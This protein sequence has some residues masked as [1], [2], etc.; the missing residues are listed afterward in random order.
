[1]TMNT[2]TILSTVLSADESIT[3]SQRARVLQI[4]KGEPEAVQAPIGKLLKRSEVAA[5]L[6]VSPAMID[7]YCR[8][9]GLKK[10]RLGGQSRATGIPEDSVRE[11]IKGEHNTAISQAS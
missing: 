3:D 8:E 6:G 1:M 4:L 7:H 9:R 5:I 10:I 11:F 2:E